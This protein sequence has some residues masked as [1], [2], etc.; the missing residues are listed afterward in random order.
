M[1]EFM[2]SKRI[3]EATILGIFLCAGLIILG[4]VLSNGLLKMKM[5]DRTVTV[6][7]LSERDVPATI[8]IW[9][10]KFSET[11]NDLTNLY[12]A[13]QKKTDMIIEFLKA[14]GFTETDISI[15]T[16]AIVDRQAE[17]TLDAERIQFRYSADSSISVYSSRVDAVRTTMR[18]IVELGKQGIV[19]SAQDYENRT[20]FLY[21]N[22]NDIKP[23]MIEEATKNARGVAEKFAKDSNSRLVKIKTASQGQFSIEDRD[24]N[25]PHIKKVRVV[26]TVEYYLSD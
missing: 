26:S 4:Y 25:T 5:L 17:G 2:N 9:P 7:G 18:K 21:T 14:N 8:A 22:L 12:S 13:I 11:D 23:A 19:I 3:A 20:Q 1:E 15:A 10:I 24:S 16:P 6:K